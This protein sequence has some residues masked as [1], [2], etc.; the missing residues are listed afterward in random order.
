M[1]LPDDTPSR[2][3]IA[4]ERLFAEHGEEATSL[5][6][7]TRAAMSNAAAVHY[8]FGGR[9]GLLVAVLDRHLAPLAARRRH[10]LDA[11]RDRPG[12]PVPVADVLAAALRPDLELLAKL[13][14][15]RV[16][17]ARLIGR[18]L[19]RQDGVADHPDSFVRDCTP[20]LQASLPDAD[21]REIGRRL[22]L[23]R[24]TV[25]LV[26]ASAGDATQPGPL[27]SNDVDTQ[28]Q[29]LAAFC[30]GGVTAPWPPLPAQRGPGRSGRK[31]KKRR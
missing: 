18:S 17:V 28:V 27:G 22:W 15:H 11:L 13:R 8:H 5:R 1:T 30:A 20:Y 7:I 3:V 31:D 10:L 2:L 12:G 24:G 23:V 16:E 26:F 29:R 9:D 4:A 21:Q 25:A 19:A 6:A 14:K